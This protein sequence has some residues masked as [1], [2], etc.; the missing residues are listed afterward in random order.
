MIRCAGASALIA[1]VC[2]GFLAWSQLSA[3]AGG[4]TLYAGSNSGSS[5]D[6][7]SPANACSLGTALGKAPSGGTIQLITPGNEAD[8][9]TF[10]KGNFTINQSV[11]IT[12]PQPAILDGE[13]VGTVL[14][15]SP[16]NGDPFDSDTVVLDNLVIQHGSATDGGGINDSAQLTLNQVKLDRNNATYGGGVFIRGG[17]VESESVTLTANQSTFSKDTA[18]E[19]GGAI[20]DNGATVTLSHGTIANDTAKDGGGAYVGPDNLDLGNLLGG[21]STLTVANSSF[22]LDRASQ[23]GGAID[24]TDCLDMFLCNSP[25]PPF[26]Y[27]VALS[28]DKTTFTG[29][30]ASNG[31]AI[32]NADFHEVNGGLTVPGTGSVTISASSFTGNHATTNGGAIDSGDT[33]GVGKLSVAGSTFAKNAAGTNGGAID[34]ADG[35]DQNEGPLRVASTQSALSISSSTFSS[36]S[37]MQDGGAV[38]NANDVITDMGS[39]GFSVTVTLSTFTG[40]SAVRGG[41]IINAD[42]GNR[43]YSGL[44]GDLMIDKSTLS[45]NTASAN[46]GGIDNGDVNGIGDVTLTQSTLSGNAAKGKGGG[47]DNADSGGGMATILNSTFAGN[48]AG[49]TGGAI[50]NGDAVGDGNLIATSTTFTTNT[51]PKAPILAQIGD[52]YDSSQV[53]LA[54][55]VFDGTC[56]QTNGTWQDG[57]Y[58]IGTDKSCMNNG[59]AD[60]TT[61]GEIGLQPLADNGGPTK[62]AAPSQTGPRG[63]PHFGIVLITAIMTV[64]STTIPLCPPL[65][66]RGDSRP[67]VLLANTCDAGSYEVPKGP[68]N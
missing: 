21:K 24:D 6:C 37:A 36:N 41:A 30:T 58:N 7:S 33:G 15:I 67:G 4:T 47:L 59:T 26:F 14:T 49:D 20:F 17:P 22:S 31:G 50:D 18:S 54:A 64:N 29:D 43:G 60:T 53:H 48:D 32:D 1:A 55:D 61:S 2:A 40:N 23:D 25:N 52:S 66:Q 44:M 57:G 10:Y 34:Q 19:D 3:Q 16:V 13:G 27:R 9:S 11:V 46:G 65:D 28:V 68:P 62:T 63:D 38:S 8:S 5:T 35:G 42:G 39:G 45:M 12:A 51:A 56:V